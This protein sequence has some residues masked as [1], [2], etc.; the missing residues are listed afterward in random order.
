M[1]EYISILGDSMILYDK[2]GKECNYEL[3]HENFINSGTTAR[4]YRINDSECLKI[5]DYGYFPR[6]IFD[7]LSNIS[8]DSF[9]KLGIPFFKKFCICAYTME[10]FNESSESILE[11]PTEYTLDNFEK[12]YND[13]VKLSSYGFKLYD[14][15]WKNMIVGDSQMKVIDFDFYDKPSD[16]EVNFFNID[17]LRVAFKYLYLEAIKLNTRINVP[18]VHKLWEFID[19]LFDINDA[20]YDNPPLTLKRKM[21]TVKKPIDLFLK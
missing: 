6:E 9:V 20:D 3:G 16:E 11:K 17:N 19:Y 12:I 8:L 14:L 13:V 21:S 2:D 5:I 7:L 4:V 1:L 10:Y 15:C 18:N